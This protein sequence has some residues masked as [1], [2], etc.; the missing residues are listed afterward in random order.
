M[1]VVA[2]DGPIT[3]QR[4]SALMQVAKLAGMR[5]KYV[6]F[7]SAFADRSAPTFRRLISEL[8]WGT[9]AWFRS[10]PEKVLAL[11]QGEAAEL[12]TLFNY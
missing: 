3:E 7:L 8:A 1:E 2:T 10:E 12:V 4:K 6:Y 5:P 11:R 9:F